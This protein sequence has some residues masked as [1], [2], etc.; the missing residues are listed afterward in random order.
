MFADNGKIS[1]RQTASLLFGDWI[2]KML[3]LL[4]MLRKSLSGWDFLLAA[5]L[6]GVWV[7][8]YLM[9][10]AKI[11]GSLRGSFTHF[12]EERLG[13]YPARIAGGLY[14]LY[15]L[16]NVTFLARM[17][18]KICVGF[19]LPETSENVLSAAVLAVGA[20]SAFGDRQTRARAAEFFVFPIA[21]ALAV[22]LLASFGN[23]RMAYFQ[24][25]EGFDAAQIF[26]RSGAVFAAFSGAS[27]LL[28]EAAHINRKG[29]EFRRALAC[30]FLITM[31]FLLAAFAAALGVL[32][33]GSLLRLS[34]PVLTL[35]GSASL[36][37]GFLQ[38]WD[39]VFL[40]FLLFSLL[41]ACASSFHFMR[42]IAAEIAP[43]K[44]KE[45]N[46]R[47]AWAVCLLS[48]FLLW[49]TGDYETAQNLFLRWA[50][51]CLLP[52]TAAIPVL[53]WVIE[54]CVTK[55]KLTKK[56]LAKG[57]AVILCVLFF[58][59]CASREMEDRAFALAM[60]LN[61][62]GE[63]LEGGFGNFLVEGQSVAEIQEAYQKQMDKFLDLGHLKAIVLGK[64]LL[65]D[66]ERMREV[67]LELEQMPPVSRSCLVF[68]HDYAGGESYL[69]EL[70]ESGRE[71]G[72]YLSDRYQ[73]NPY[74]TEVQTLGDLLGGEAL[75]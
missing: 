56:K 7:F 61:L 21:A 10:L 68:S 66:G 50:L 1:A 23:V 52:V 31:L 16:L 65:E 64:T 71:P 74:D 55:K 3:L 53:I 13:R 38:R 12:L 32:G 18:G 11:S 6:G 5:A 22:M 70:K 43:Q 63:T 67:L 34:F 17:T 69:N 40:A 46:R 19:L 8:F 36:P 24:V 59:G 27:V 75:E 35:M 45:K 41:L 72:E 44:I 49:L 2:A 4:P 15:L 20:A 73:N 60:E 30:G 47:C 57:A 9:L 37:G 29:R 39:A 62:K 48:F 42:N 33:E 28:Y 25:G 26:L 51:C 58:T 14:L 54:K